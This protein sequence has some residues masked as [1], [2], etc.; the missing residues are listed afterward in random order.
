MFSRQTKEADIKTLRFLALGAAVLLLSGCFSSNWL[1]FVNRDGSGRITMD[2]SMEKSVV[3]MMQGFGGESDDPP[4]STSEDLMDEESMQQLASSMGEGVRFVSA[5][6]LAPGSPSI[7]YTAIFEFDD[8][9]TVS[10]NPMAGAPSDEENS[11]GGDAVSFDFKD[12]FRPTLLITLEQ[13]DDEETADAA[14]EAQSA[15]EA[16]MMA[17]MMKPFLGGMS[18]SVAVEVDGE[19]RTTNASFV[20]KNRVTIMD[21]DMG[22]ILDNDA[23]FS[24]VVASNS[25]SEEELQDDLSAAGIRIET[26]ELVSV[27]F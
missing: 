9:R 27:E 6:P 8:I 14:E 12:G 10:I 5:K 13:D 25:V 15:E 18:F 24:R 1:V 16:A 4:P 3:E 19:I 21:F 17:S 7:G 26:R 22:K 23:L 11:D 20:D 2:F